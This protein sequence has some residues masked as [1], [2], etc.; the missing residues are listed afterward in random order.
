MGYRIYY[1]MDGDELVILLLA[2][3]KPT[4]GSDIALAQAYWAEY[5]RG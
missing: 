1:G 4:Q 3:A 2:G 5:K